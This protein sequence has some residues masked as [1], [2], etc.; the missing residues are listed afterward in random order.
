VKVWDPKKTL[1]SIGA[2]EERKKKRSTRVA[3]AIQNELAVLLVGKIQD[4]RL[5]DLSITRVEVSEDLSI[6]RIFFSII[7]DHSNIKLAKK[8]LM[9]A[10]GFLRS[11]IAKTINLRF[12]PDLDFRYD[13]IGEKVAELEEIF[14]EIADERNSREDDSQGVG[15]DDQ[16]ND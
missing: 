7:G 16:K 12:T 1:H 4:P 8:G 14:Q 5:K 3:Q 11:H 2:G 6:A 15:E 10:K 13:D 9:Q